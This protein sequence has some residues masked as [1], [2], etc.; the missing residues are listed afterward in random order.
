MD[1]KHTELLTKHCR[2]CANKLGRVAYN[3]VKYSTLLE[4]AFDVSVAKDQPEVHPA[5]F[6]NRCYLTAQRVSKSNQENKYTETSCRSFEWTRNSDENCNFCSTVE[7]KQ[8]GGRP[9]K[10][11]SGGRPSLI[12]Q[13]VKA[14]A[15]KRLNEGNKLNPEL[16]VEPESVDISNLLCCVCNK[17]VDCPLEVSCGHLISLDCCITS[18]RDRTEFCCPSC[19]CNSSVDVASFTRVTPVVQQLLEGL[20]LHCPV[21][22][23]LT[24]LGKLTQHQESSCKTHILHTHEPTALISQPAST[25]PTALERRAAAGILQRI[26]AQEANL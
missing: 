7:D 25:P 20:Q 14:V 15:G 3:S 2:I 12:I 5:K 26:M 22:H 8:L 4:E 13:H 16:F 17:V 10:R 21:C 24:H 18:I 23:Q 6:C 9:N 19:D 11:R 1:D